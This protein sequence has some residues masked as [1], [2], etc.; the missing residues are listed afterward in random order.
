M[1]LFCIKEAAEDK[2]LGTSSICRKLQPRLGCFCSGNSSCQAQEYMGEIPQ[3]N[4]AGIVFNKPL[5]WK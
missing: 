1:R 3:F 4:P 2:E 5:K